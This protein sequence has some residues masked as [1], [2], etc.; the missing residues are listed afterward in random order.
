MVRQ[1]IREK[2]IKE[3][4]DI[5]N[6]LAE[7]KNKHIQ[8]KKDLRKSM[9]DENARKKEHNQRVCELECDI[10]QKERDL[11]LAENELQTI[12]SDTKAHN[13][14]MQEKEKTLNAFK[15]K[16]GREV[17]DQ[18]KL[19][20]FIEEMVTSVKQN[21]ITLSGYSSIF[22]RPWSNGLAL[23]LN[24]MV[25]E[26]VDPLWEEIVNIN[27]ELDAKKKEFDEQGL[28]FGLKDKKKV[29]DLQNSYPEWMDVFRIAL[30]RLG[31]FECKLEIEGLDLVKQFHYLDIT[32][33]SNEEEE[34]VQMIE[35]GLEKSVST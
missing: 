24:S 23:L 6:S 9:E 17:I 27:K 29:L 35:Y 33:L 20:A 13:Q 4:E 22:N 5:I 19:G 16:C 30:E 12:I 26:G 3:S 11:E 15:N 21:S 28:A 10:E 2:A 1:S 25:T 31:Q 34:P 32:K 8:K 18:L 7:M 14:L